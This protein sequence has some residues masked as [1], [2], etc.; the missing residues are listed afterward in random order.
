MNY[1]SSAPVIVIVALAE[2]LLASVWLVVISLSG[3]LLSESEMLVSSVA[4]ARKLANIITSIT[5]TSK[6]ISRFTFTPLIQ[7]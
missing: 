2:E 1:S 6:R 4:D 5:K 7:L 3:T